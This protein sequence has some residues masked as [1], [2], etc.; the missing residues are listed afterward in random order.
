MDLVEEATKLLRSAPA[1]ALVAYYTGTLPAMLGFLYFFS[2]MTRS[3]FG[4]SRLV[5]AALVMAFLYLWMKCWQAI[6]AS[7]LRATLHRETP[8]PWTIGRLV[9]LAHV[10]T[11]VQPSGLFARLIAAQIVIPYVWVYA[12]Y[13]NVGVLADGE[14]RPLSAILRE[15]AGQARLWPRQ[16][17]YALALLFCFALVLALNIGVALFAAPQLLKSF[18]GIETTFSKSPMSLLNTTVFA[19]VGAFT[20]LAFDPVRKA[21]FVLRCFYGGALRSGRDLRVELRQILRGANRSLA[22]VLLFLFL[23]DGSVPATCGADP[24]PGPPPAEQLNQSIERVLQRREF[25]WRLPREKAPENE[26]GVIAMFLHDFFEAVERKIA[27]GWKW[28]MKA[29]EKIVNFFGGSE[30]RP[31]SSGLHWSG[32]TARPALY[33]AIAFA[34]GVALFVFWRKRRGRSPVTVAAAVTP[35]TPDLHSDDLVADQLP[36][37]E[38][39]RLA[40]EMVQAGELRLALRASYLAGL[41]HLGHR[42]LI[43]IA[44]HKSNWEYDRELRRRARAQGDLLRAFDENLRAFERAWYGLHSVS[45]DLLAAFNRNLEQIRAC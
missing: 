30:V 9:R 28:A 6:F 34:I 18:F 14:P 44:R 37:D 41:A 16:A 24:L 2:D 27:L 45:N 10:Q 5:E 29:L 35:A 40:A 19:T 20:Y 39:L 25:T 3:A 21:V 38:W 22:R 1:S 17:H 43:T 31:G 4:P 11:S 13:Q 7:G 33:A 42:H 12:F 26:R 15:A 8:A 36:E 32:K 23:V